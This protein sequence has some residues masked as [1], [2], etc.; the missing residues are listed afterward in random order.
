MI[1]EYH[2]PMKRGLGLS[3]QN[4]TYEMKHLHN[5]YSCHEYQSQR[6]DYKT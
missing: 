4:T 3:F 5:L 1:Y 6:Y 2:H